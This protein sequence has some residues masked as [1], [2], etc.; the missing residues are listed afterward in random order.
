[1][2][3]PSSLILPHL[4]FFVLA[5]KHYNGSMKD[6]NCKKKDFT[7]QHVLD[8]DIDDLATIPDFFLA[9]RLL[10]DPNT[11]TTIATPVRVPGARVMPTGNLANVIALPT[12]NTSLSIPENQVRAGYYDYQPGGAIMRLAGENNPATFLML[13]KYTEG[14]MLVQS[15]GFLNMENGHSYLPGVQYYLGENGEPVTDQSTTGQKLFV[16]I[17]DH[18]LLVNGEF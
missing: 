14:R 11:G 17:D 4:L 1:M 3:Y 12:N 2:K 8:T 18:F 10:E 5:K 6:C 7:V 15:T 13:G 16:P 9:G